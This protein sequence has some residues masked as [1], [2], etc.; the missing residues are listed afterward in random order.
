MSQSNQSDEWLMGQVALGNRDHL[1]TLVRRYASPLLT[2]VERMVGNR[3]RSEELV[4]EVF[5]RVWIKRK[6]YKFPKTFRAW[7][8]TIATNHCRSAFRRSKPQAEPLP[9]FGLDVPASADPSPVDTAVSTE[10]AN[11]VAAA[12]AQLPPQQ[13]MVVTLRNFNGLSFAEIAEAIGRTEVTARSHM[14]HA[15]SSMRRYLEPRM[16]D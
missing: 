3:H 8:F 2:Y 16:G 10:T 11:L 4:Q 13:R 7:L 12:V 9:D 15:L 6:T 1:G 14:H 5:L